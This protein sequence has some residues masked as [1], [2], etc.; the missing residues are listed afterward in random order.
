MTSSV[1]DQEARNMATAAHSAIIV[2]EKV[3]AQRWLS[4]M[5]TMKD[6]KRIIAWGTTGLI[7]SMGGLIVYLATHPH[8]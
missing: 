3:C 7:G 8:S 2:H 6:I 1:I 5:D 4:T